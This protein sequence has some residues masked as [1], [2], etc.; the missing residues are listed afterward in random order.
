M[1][2]QDIEGNRYNPVQ[3]FRSWTAC[4]AIIKRGNDVGDSIFVG[5]PSEREARR[6]V[7]SATLEW[8]AREG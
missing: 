7:H 8:P 3:V 4:K 5:L 2:L 1:V 6:T